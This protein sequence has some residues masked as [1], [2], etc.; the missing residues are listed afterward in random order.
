[1]ETQE[2]QIPSV[3]IVLL[4]QFMV[5]ICLFISL[6]YGQRALIILTLLIL[7]IAI[8]T[9]LWSRLSLSGIGF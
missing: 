1:M 9:N 5:G 4:V 8:G 3:Y 6:L 2:R 7:G